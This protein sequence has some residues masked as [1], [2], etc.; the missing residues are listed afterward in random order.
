MSSHGGL[1]FQVT[2]LCGAK[3]G[4]DT[5]FLFFSFY[6]KLLNTHIPIGER[7]NQGNIILFENILTIKL[8]TILIVWGFLCTHSNV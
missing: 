2:L 8:G 4:S 7:V 5:F 6:Q 3:R 1:V